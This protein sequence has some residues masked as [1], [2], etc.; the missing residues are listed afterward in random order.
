MCESSRLIL[1]SYNL[2]NKFIRL[3]LDAWGPEPA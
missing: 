2:E 1:N 3:D